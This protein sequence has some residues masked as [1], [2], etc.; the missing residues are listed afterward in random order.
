MAAQRREH[1]WVMRIRPSIAP[2]LAA[3][4]LAF[5]PLLACDSGAPPAAK[6]AAKSQPAAPAQPEQPA[7][8][9]KAPEQEPAQ[10][11]AQA[12]EPEPGP[13]DTAPPADPEPVGEEDDP[14]SEPAAPASGLAPIPKA[15]ENVTDVRDP[16]LL[17]DGTPAPNKEAFRRLPVAKGDKAP[18][19]GAGENGLHLDEL[20]VGRGW[21]K[22]RCD[23]VGQTFTVGVDDRVNICMRVIHPRGESEL[24]MIYWERDGKLNQRSKVRVS[25]I[26]AYLTR[27]WLPITEARKGK[28][29]AT[30]KTEKGSEL[31]AVEFEIE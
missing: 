18:I 15:A 2:R 19:G 6:Q 4:M 26:H 31:A 28:W 17:P 27:G 21:H 20:Q 30:I 23:L 24:L 7:E 14:E 22:S 25:E 9:E 8:V 13:V 10:P 1:G 5:G 29:K 11:A 12:G 16:S 3:L